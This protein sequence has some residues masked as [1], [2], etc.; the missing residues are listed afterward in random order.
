MSY[1]VKAIVDMINPVSRLNQIWVFQEAALC[2]LVNRLLFAFKPCSGVNSVNKIP[3][4]ARQLNV[5]SQHLDSSFHHFQTWRFGLIA[6]IPHD[7]TAVFQSSQINQYLFTWAKFQ[8]L[9]RPL[10][11]CCAI[12]SQGI[13]NNLHSICRIHK[14]HEQCRCNRKKHAINVCAKL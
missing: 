7:T 4:G 5:I 9:N 14:C 2:S 11:D 12:R 13:W 10:G 1:V 8:R 3:T 6:A